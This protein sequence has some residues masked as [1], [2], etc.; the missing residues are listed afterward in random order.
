MDPLW[1]RASPA[2][3]SSHPLRPAQSWP[4]TVRATSKIK[5]RSPHYRDC[6]DE[7]GNDNSIHPQFF[8]SREPW[9]PR[10]VVAAHHGLAGG[11]SPPSPDFVCE[12]DPHSTRG[13]VRH[14]R[15]LALYGSPP[16]RSFIAF[17]CAP[18]PPAAGAPLGHTH[19][20]NLGIEYVLGEARRRIDPGTYCYTPSVK[21]R[22]RYRSADAHDVVRAAGWDVTTPGADLFALE[23]AAW[24]RCL[25]LAAER[26][27]GR[28]C[29]A[30]RHAACA[31]WYLT[32]N[33][34]DIWDG[35][36]P[37][38]RLRPIAPQIPVCRRLRPDRAAG[39]S[40][41]NERDGSP[42]G[43]LVYA[44]CLSL[45]GTGRRAP[46][47]SVV[48]RRAAGMCCS[49]RTRCRRCMRCGGETT[50]SRLRLA[51]AGRGLARESGGLH[52]MLPVTLLP[53]AGRLGAHSRWILDHWPDFTIPHVGRA[54]RAGRLRPA[55]PD[56]D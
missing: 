17:R 33:G 44:A 26:G 7:P 6:R 54:L 21:L 52:T 14:F 38:N 31:R 50:T 53:L 9:R 48:W 37:P 22:D 18:A 56:G 40:G 27:R 49:C 32:E 30:P 5:I 12:T 3:V 51:Q 34:V 55:R 13:G 43:D 42:K 25:R 10:A 2:V 20:D 4:G 39:V 15:I 11:M 46:L 41:R 16:A 1:C 28:D 36:D 19:D 35:V 23:H 47:G 24:A 45:G 8:V 29:G